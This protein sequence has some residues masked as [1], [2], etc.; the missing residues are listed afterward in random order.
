M[1]LQA[2]ADIERALHVNLENARVTG[3]SPAAS[4]MVPSE[5][6][7]SFVAASSKNS[8]FRQ[9]MTLSKIHLMSLSV[10]LKSVCCVA[11]SGIE[12]YQFD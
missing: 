3:V 5:S 1:R 12:L 4:S 7:D 11:L 9:S 2:W 8:A 10:H 6:V